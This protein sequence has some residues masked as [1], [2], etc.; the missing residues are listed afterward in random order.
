MTHTTTLT[1]NRLLVKRHA[2]SSS[3]GHFQG[4][5]KRQRKEPK[6]LHDLFLRRLKS[7]AADPTNP[8]T[9]L[10]RGSEIEK[11]SGLRQSTYSDICHGAEPRL[12]QIE[13]LAKAL[14]VEPWHLLIEE[15]ELVRLLTGN[16]EKARTKGSNVKDFPRPPSLLGEGNEKPGRKTSD[17]KNRTR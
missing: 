13:R 10:K 6:G 1:E 16:T 8:P 5:G 17:R 12:T 2:V 4:V 14:K 7:L 15:S 3:V 9:Y 11:A